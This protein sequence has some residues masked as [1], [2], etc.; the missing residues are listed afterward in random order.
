M[1]T[2]LWILV[3][4]GLYAF[5]FFGVWVLCRGAAL[6]DRMAEQERRAEA[7]VLWSHSDVEFDWSVLE[8]RHGLNGVRDVVAPLEDRHV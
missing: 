3:G 2:G 6:G 4:I 8:G 1:S 7:L 5:A